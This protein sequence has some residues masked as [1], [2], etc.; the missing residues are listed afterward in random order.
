MANTPVE[1]FDDW[2]A[3]YPGVLEP[4]FRLIPPEIAPAFE[5]QRNRLDYRNNELRKLFLPRRNIELY[6]DFTDDGTCNAVAGIHDLLGLIAV[7]KGAIMLPLEMFFNIFSHPAIL[8]G[9][10]HNKDERIGP[11]HR[12]GL[13]TDYDALCS[14]R[15][16]AGRSVWPKKPID[17]VRTESAQLCSEIIW[18]FIV[19]HEIVH[20]VHGHVGY[21]N[22]PTRASRTSQMIPVDLEMQAIEVWADSMAISVTLRGLLTKSWESVLWN[23]FRSPEQ[24]IFIWSFAIYTLFRI[25]GMEIDPANLHGD[26]PPIALRFQIAMENA[27][28][29][30][31]LVVP[32]LNESLFRAV[33]VQGITQAER[34]IVYCGGNRLGNPIS[35]DDQ[36]VAAHRKLLADHH[37]N[38]L[39]AKL[40]AYS[41]VGMK[42]S[43]A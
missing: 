18:S 2:I 5:K 32:G 30:A 4:R 3:Q 11:R 26:H 39:R 7:S 1:A 28:A 15:V 34:A 6:L 33:A 9:V 38:V 17:P 41:Y 12:E 23:V 24:K 37:D 36:R 8:P 43:A 31:I 16:K 20:I 29:A 13:L 40:P 35:L 25:W 42:D 27:A 21:L 10:G 14:M 22:T 19:M